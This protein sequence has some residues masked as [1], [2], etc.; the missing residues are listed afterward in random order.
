[1]HGAWRFGS[2]S[3]LAHLARKREGIAFASKI[4]YSG[5]EN[6]CITAHHPDLHTEQ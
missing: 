5:G 2:A 4:V 3:Y 1:M 6:P